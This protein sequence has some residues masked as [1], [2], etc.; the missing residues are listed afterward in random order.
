MQRLFILVLSLM[1]WGLPPARSQPDTV[2]KERQVKELP[3]SVR[4]MIT[5]LGDDKEMAVNGVDEIEV[6]GLII[7]ETISKMGHDFYDMFYSQWT[8][9]DVDFNYTI[10]IQ[11]KPVPGMGSVVSVLVNEEE[12][13]SQRIQPRAELIEAVAEYAH[14]RLQSYLLNY[15]DIQRQLSGQ[16]LSGTGIY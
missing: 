14:R 9:P 5:R 1:F 4:Q 6:D 12:L 10:Y 7:D 16:D 11:E 3:K 2:R 13:V 15:E 8:P